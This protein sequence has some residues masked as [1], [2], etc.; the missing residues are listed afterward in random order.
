MDARLGLRD[1]RDVPGH[2][3]RRRVADA[4]PAPALRE[5]LTPTD[6]GLTGRRALVT[7]SSRGIGFG[8]AQAL[9]EEGAQV[10]LAAR[11][12]VVLAGAAGRIS[13]AG[14]Q[15][16]D[17]ADPDQAEQLVAAAVRR[18][19]GLDILVTNS[20]DPPAGDFGSSERETW[21]HAYR[22]TLLSA[23]S[24][25]RAALP[26]LAE[27][28]RGRV[29]NITSMSARW[30][31]EGRLFSNTYRPA[32]TGMAKT[33][34]AEVATQGITVNNIAPGWVLTDAVR[35]GMNAEQIAAA[36]DSVPVG[37]L[38]EPAEVGALCAFLCSSQASYITGQ[39]IS[40]DGGLV[41]SLL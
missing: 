39:T 18:L 6:L 28:G 27:S 5:G 32:V 25:I 14:F 11:D 33:V 10:F 7:A 24:L 1:E 16:V 4:F 8:C 20:G 12:E 30:S 22:L 17:L 40:I 21:D 9:A 35:V 26:A 13:A 23:V 2:R 29:V 15:G 3:D 34:A 36:A 31:L 38:A 19:G 37:R 41:R